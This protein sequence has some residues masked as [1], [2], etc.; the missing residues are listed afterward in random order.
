MHLVNEHFEKN[1]P[2]SGIPLALAVITTCVCLILCFLNVLGNILI[3]LSVVL[4]PNKNLRTPFSW[5]IVNLAAADLI[6]GTL[7]DPISVSIHFK[8]CLGKKSTD[9]EHTVLHMSYFISCTASA[10]SIA[11]LAVERYLAVRKPTTYRNKMTNKRIMVTVA[12]IWLIS[13][14]LP[15]I[16]LEVGYILY[17]FVFVNASLVLA[18]S[19]TCF[20]YF[21]MWRK[22]KE[23]SY[24][25]IANHNRGIASFP[26]T[27]CE[28]S[29][30][31]STSLNNSTTSNSSQAQIK[32]KRKLPKCSLSSLLPCSAAMVRQLCSFISS[33]SVNHAVVLLCIGFWIWHSFQS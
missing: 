12:V 27:E 2:L 33:T 28:E 31:S 18:I 20:T 30:S 21:L 7:T 5:L 32:W 11:S 13:L 17:S 3:I 26:S 16:Y 1:C 19:I 22:I 15:N 8:L 29:Q 6:T 4:D 23:R 25:T 24:K 10:L 14:T 9:A